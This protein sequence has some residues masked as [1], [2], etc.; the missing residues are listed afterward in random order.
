MGKGSTLPVRQRKRSKKNLAEM[1]AQSKPQT[2][3]AV[4]RTA[5]SESQ[6]MR[7]LCAEEEETGREA[8]GGRDPKG[9]DDKREGSQQG[10]TSFSITPA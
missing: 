4:A 5:S 7:P 3:T 2:A 1:A 10:A 9:R 8:K 6:K